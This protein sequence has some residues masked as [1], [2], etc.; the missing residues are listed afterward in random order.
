MFL[1]AASALLLPGGVLFR[2]IGTIRGPWILAFCGF[3]IGVGIGLL[4]LYQWARVTTIAV[5][6]L[7]VGLLGIA[8][9][10]GAVRLRLAFLFA[11][12]LRLPIYA[13]IVWYLL[14]PEIRLAFGRRTDCIANKP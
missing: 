2:G 1:G 9:L 3:Y 7:D 13:V 14:K 5:T 8:L 10:N 11:Y 6:I 4:K 12:L